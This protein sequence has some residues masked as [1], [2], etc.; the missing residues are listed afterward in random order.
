MRFSSDINPKILPYFAAIMSLFTHIFWHSAYI[1]IYTKKRRPGDE[2]PRSL[3]FVFMI[4]PLRI[5][6]QLHSVIIIG[7]KFM[8]FINCPS[9]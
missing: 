6:G 5:A 7:L 1:N 9:P 4:C 8:P 2:L 3:R